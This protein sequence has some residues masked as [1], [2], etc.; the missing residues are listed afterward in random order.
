MGKDGSGKKSVIV[1][2][3]GKTLGQRIRYFREMKRM[4]QSELENKTGIKREYL[5]RLENDK[6]KNPTR[7]TLLKLA[8]GL[9][10]SLTNLIDGTEPKIPVPTIKILNVSVKNLGKD[11]HLAAPIVKSGR[12]GIRMLEQDDI[13]SYALFPKNFFGESWEVRG[14]KIGVSKKRTVFFTLCKKEEVKLQERVVCFHA[15]LGI[16]VGRVGKIEHKCIFIIH[17]NKEGVE[18]I[19][20]FKG[21][22]IIGKVAECF[23]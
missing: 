3:D 20:S 12:E 8:S 2:L 9:G 17:P 6:L 7:S 18:D 23:V 22:E 15:L 21:D 11:S 14:A 10:V 1:G 5:S 16:V 19:S 13:E 4:S